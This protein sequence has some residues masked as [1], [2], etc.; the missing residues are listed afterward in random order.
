MEH[1]QTGL[2]SC[3]R[4][5][6]VRGGSTDGSNEFVIKHCNL[7]HIIWV[8]S[9]LLDSGYQTYVGNIQTYTGLLNVF[10]SYLK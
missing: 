7:E 6:M 4:S 10:F 2:S 9:Y 1:E 8:N 3:L 5:R